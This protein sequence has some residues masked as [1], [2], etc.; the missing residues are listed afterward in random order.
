MYS[1]FNSL[2]YLQLNTMIDFPRLFA[3]NNLEQFLL[4]QI[5]W[6]LYKLESRQITSPETGNSMGKLVMDTIGN[7]Y[8]PDR[9][10]N[11]VYKLSSDLKLNK[12]ITDSNLYNIHDRF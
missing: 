5:A 9:D 6:I 11:C 12:S 4:K 1:T 10:S 3:T 7:V 8:S 2:H